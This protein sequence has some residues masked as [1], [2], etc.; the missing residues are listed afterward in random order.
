VRAHDIEIATHIVDERGDR[1]R[2]IRV[3][4]RA[5]FPPGAP[6][7]V[8]WEQHDILG[9]PIA[10]GAPALLVTTDVVVD[11]TFAVAPPRGAIA[12]GEPTIKEGAL[13]LDRTAMMIA[14]GDPGA[15]TAIR[16]RARVA[17]CG[18]GGSP[19]TQRLAVVSSDGAAASFPFTCADA[20]FADRRVALPASG[21]IWLSFSY[22]EL[23]TF[24]VSGAIP[25]VY[26]MRIDEVS[27]E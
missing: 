11:R 17:E 18:H 7:V 26:E 6:L 19:T 21:P 24:P 8:S 4:P 22:E 27:F 5:A 10:V 9:R 3:V 15:S 20:S 1:R 12:G 13:V 25:N 23:G 2:A 16:V 14:L